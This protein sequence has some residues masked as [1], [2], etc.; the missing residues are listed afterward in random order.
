MAKKRKASSKTATAEIDNAGWNEKG[1]KMRKITT[2]ADVADSEDEF[3]L[4]RDKVLLDEAP[5]AKRRR[6][7]A[8]EGKQ[9][10]QSTLN[11][12]LINS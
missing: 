2:F 12:V 9:F 7:W 6:K 11:M 1:G 4:N 3:H 8:E 5:D 10:A